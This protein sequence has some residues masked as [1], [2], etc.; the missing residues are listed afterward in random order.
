MHT[1]WT[2]WKNQFVFEV[3]G[4][5]GF[6]RIDGLGGSYGTERCLVGRRRPESGPPDVTVEEFAGPDGSWHA[7]WDEFLSAIRE[8]RQPMAN[9]ID[10][11][12]ALRLVHAVYEAS[13][14]STVVTL[15]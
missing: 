11:W 7:E 10:G 8:G 1:S 13:R 9:G 5:D 3:Y 15:D 6:V 2:Q 14:T 12:Q 4:R